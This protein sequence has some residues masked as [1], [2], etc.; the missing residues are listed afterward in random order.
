MDF[1]PSGE[2]KGC[3]DQQNMTESISDDKLGDP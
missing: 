1:D 2:L 3:R